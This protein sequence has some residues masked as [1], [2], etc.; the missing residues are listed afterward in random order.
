MMIEFQILIEDQFNELHVE[1]LEAK[2]LG[3][4]KKEAE[5]ML[6]GN[7]K[8][9]VVDEDD[10]EATWDQAAALVEGGDYES[11]DS[12]F[13]IQK[14]EELPVVE[15]KDRI[16]TWERDEYQKWEDRQEVEEDE[17]GEWVEEDEELPEIEQY[18]RAKEVYERLRHKFEAA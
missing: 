12:A 2:T 14:C 17:G 15:W 4:A 6:L 1:D 18:E 13:I 7:P 8:D 10:G 11:A 9:N 16:D 3:D 5:K